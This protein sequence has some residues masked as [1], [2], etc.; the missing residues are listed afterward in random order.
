M[1]GY[2]EDQKNWLK[3]G[4]YVDVTIENIGTLHNTFR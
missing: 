1:K 2:P 4:D 3:A